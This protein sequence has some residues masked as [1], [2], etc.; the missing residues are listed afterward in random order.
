MIMSKFLP[1]FVD[2][3]SIISSGFLSRL[4]KIITIVLENI[5]AIFIPV[6]AIFKLYECIMIL[7]VFS[8]PL[9]RGRYVAP[10]STWPPRSYRA[11]A[12]TKPSTG[13]HWGYSSTK[14]SMGTLCKRG[15]CV[16]GCVSYCVKRE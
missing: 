5:V 4:K 9:G 14:C 10:R 6:T 13:G 8:P 7:W 11:K 12:T 16:I 2:N 15:H 1:E 3:Y